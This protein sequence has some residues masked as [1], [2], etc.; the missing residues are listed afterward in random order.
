MNGGYA[1]YLLVKNKSW[2]SFRTEKSGNAYM[3][4][5][6]SGIFW[7]AALGVYGQGASLMGTLGPVIGWPMLLG[8][9]LIISNVW[10]YRSGEWK[11]AK[12]PFQILLIGLVV[13]ILAI[14][15]LG[16][17]NY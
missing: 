4:A 5:I 16:Y 12:R 17:A 10:A 14:C 3:W 6:L 7:F 13:L 11:G 1:L 8:L 15:L 2:G 9:A